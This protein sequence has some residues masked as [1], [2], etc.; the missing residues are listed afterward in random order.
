MLIEKLSH[1]GSYEGGAPAVLSGVSV[2]TIEGEFGRLD[3]EHLEGILRPIDEHFS[4]TRILSLENST[5]LGGG[6]TYPLDQLQRV[7]AWAHEHGLKVHLDGARLFNAC[8]ARGYTPADVGRCVDT[9]SVCFSKGLGCPMGSILVGSK[10]VV[11]RARRAR[12]LFGGALRQAGIVA[13]AALFAIDHHIDR[14]AEDH[15]HARLFAAEIDQI[16]GISADPGCVET[17]LV[18]FELDPKC[19]AAHTLQGR[20]EK[21][22][23]RLYSVGQHRLRACTHLNVSREDVLRAAEIMREVVGQLPADVDGAVHNGYP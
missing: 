7:G 20:L 4:P 9:I 2:R 22:G 3:I 5:N 19:G 1:I 16:D 18:F 14:L 11:T 15:E 10:E 6:R 13:G 21:S 12:K 17:N 23:V 8:V